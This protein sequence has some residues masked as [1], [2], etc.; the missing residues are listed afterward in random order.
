ML[1]LKLLHAFA[2]I[3]Q[4]SAI[5]V[6][7]NDDVFWSHTAKVSTVQFSSVFTSKFNSLALEHQLLNKSFGK[8]D[9]LKQN[10]FW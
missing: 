7:K 3:T 8:L 1:F 2:S 5:T 6:A 9:W 4:V 10:P